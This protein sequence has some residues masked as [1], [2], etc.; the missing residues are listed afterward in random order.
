[1]RKP[2]SALTPE[3]RNILRKWLTDRPTRTV[4]TWHP[5]HTFHY[6]WVPTEEGGQV[7]AV[8]R[9]AVRVTFTRWGRRDVIDQE[10]VTVTGLRDAWHCVVAWLGLPNHVAADRN[11]FRGWATLGRR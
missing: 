5:T 4:V 2:I 11:A 7:V 9:P 8:T 6:Q 1:V 10:G 3:Q